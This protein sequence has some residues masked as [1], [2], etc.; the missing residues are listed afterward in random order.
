M[1]SAQTDLVVEKP[2][3]KTGE[4]PVAMP[5]KKREP[6][7]PIVE[8]CVSDYESARQAFLG[9]ASS[10]ELC[11]NRSEGG[12]TPS[13]GLIEQCVQLVKSTNTE[14]HVLIRPRPGDFVY[15]DE[16]CQVIHKD[17]IAAKVA[18]ADGIVC[19]MLTPAGRVDK[20]RM[21][22]FRALSQPLQLTFHRAFDVMAMSSAH[23]DHGGEEEGVDCATALADIVD[24]GCDRLLT[25]GRHSTA[26]QA[27]HS[28][29]LRS[30]IQQTEGRL[31]V[32]AA[33]GVS[34][35]NVQTIISESFA[36]AVHAGSAVTA[37]SNCS[38]NSVSVSSSII[39]PEMAGYLCVQE[40]AV[41]DLVAA[42]E[43]AWLQ[44]EI[45]TPAML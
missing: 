17:I 2:I 37:H 26:L 12:T 32:V 35:D 39:A 1:A 15:S 19:G 22:V 43:Q 5:Y 7:A 27:V 6:S 28:G 21:A 9:G 30:I 10:L 34:R 33:S 29:A 11:S 23:D 36:T 25:S 24:C 41:R 44:L 38:N 3:Q 4:P 31:L 13:I 20:T 40:Q 14:L 16:E 42:A 8:I 45:D 18:G